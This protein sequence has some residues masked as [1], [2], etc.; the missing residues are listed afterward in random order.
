MGQNLCIPNFKDEQPG[1]T[2]YLTPLTI[3]LFGV[4][5]NVS[6][7]KKE[8]KEILGKDTINACI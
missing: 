6:I 2:Y 3:L 4:V 8:E 1:D 7:T 5:D